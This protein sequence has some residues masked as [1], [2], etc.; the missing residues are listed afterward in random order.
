MNGGSSKVFQPIKFAYYTE[1]DQVV[2]FDSPQTFQ[3]LSAAS[4]ATTFFVGRRKEKGRDSNPADYMG[5]LN[6][7][8]ECGAP[9]FSLTWPK[10]AVVRA[11]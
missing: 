3:A 5:T 2:Y 9:G 1:C 11:D 10:E 8:R 6:Q 4:N 7:W